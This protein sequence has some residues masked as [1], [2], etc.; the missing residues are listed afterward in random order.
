M[1]TATATTGPARDNT[2][3]ALRLFAWGIVFVTFAFLVENY[4][5]HWL[6]LPGARSVLSGGG[7]YLAAGVYVLAGVLALAAARSPSPDGLRGDSAR[8]T[9]IAGYIA[10]AAFWIVLLV[11]VADSLISFLRV[12]DLLTGLVGEDLA[13]SL[14]LPQWRG[15]YVHMPLAALA[16]VIAFFTRGVSFVWLS[17]LVVVVQLVIVIGRF[18]FSYEQAFIADLVRM[19]YAAL[20]LFSSAYTLVEEGH[21]R[22]D[23][24]YASMGVRTKALVNGIGAVV[25]GMSLMW[26]ILVLGTATRASPI[27]GPFIS[28][29]QGQQTYGL[30]TK[31]WM[32]AY[33]AIY[34]VL[35]MVQFAAMVLK[36]GADW[37]EEPDPATPSAP[38]ATAKA[39]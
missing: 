20:F 38:P 31:Y 29:E 39:D 5:V 30:A 12:E 21:V 34:A 28:Y 17:L 22:V 32:A 3:F 16:L 11:G 9:A 33:L 24:F 8:I 37:R 10:R 26:V 25:L 2:A 15:P 27:I 4:L 7:G 36:S 1:T 14:G 13:T 18:V 6:N 35:M 19:W 23:V